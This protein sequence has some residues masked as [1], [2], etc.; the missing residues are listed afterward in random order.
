MALVRRPDWPPLSDPAGPDP[1]TLHQFEVLA[2]IGLATVEPAL[3][4]AHSAFACLVA[5]SEQSA[6]SVDALGAD[7]AAGA[8][9]LGAMRSEAAADTLAPE[10]AAAADQ[11]AA[12]E[13]L[14]GEVATALGE[15]TEPPAPTPPAEPQVAEPEEP[16]EPP[17]SSGHPEPADTNLEPAPQQWWWW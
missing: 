9:E 12:L 3:D 15:T 13:T 8:E 10:L 6:Q 16:V 1:A 2:A 5:Q 7:L 17:I 11:D 14:T 4:A